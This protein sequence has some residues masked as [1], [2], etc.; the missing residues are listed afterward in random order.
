MS[1]AWR[2]GWA[3]GRAVDGG[4]GGDGDRHLLSSSDTQYKMT[5][6]MAVWP[7]EASEVS[8]GGGQAPG[9]PS[10]GGR[11]VWAEVCGP[12][13]TLQR[14]LLPPCPP[15]PLTSTHVPQALCWGH[16]SKR[17]TQSFDLTERTFYLERQTIYRNKIISNGCVG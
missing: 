13:G 3:A 16:G 12:F 6:S 15:S 9:C 17:D 4:A 14:G 7:S 10:L 11:Q 8:Q 2:L 5:I 1:P